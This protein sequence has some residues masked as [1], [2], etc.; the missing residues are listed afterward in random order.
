[1]TELQNTFQISLS[2]YFVSHPPVFTGKIW[3]Y[4]GYYWP[5]EA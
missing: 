2:L 5:K 4:L 1:M 3:R